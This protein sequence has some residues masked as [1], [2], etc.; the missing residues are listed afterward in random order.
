MAANKMTPAEKRYWELSEIYLAQYQ[1][2]IEPSLKIMLAMGVIVE[3]ESDL[4]AFHG[5]N[6]ET[7]KS[8]NQKDRLNILRKSLDAFSISAERNLQFRMV[9]NK[10]YNETQVKDCRIQELEQEIIKLNQQLEGI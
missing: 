1:D 9:M 10:M 5:K 2:S 6:A 8:K 7:E 3:M 4:A